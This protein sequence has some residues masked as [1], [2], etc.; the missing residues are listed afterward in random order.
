MRKIALLALPAVSMAFG[1]A[2]PFGTTHGLARA[3]SARS[4]AVPALRMAV[5]EVN[6]AEDLDGQIAGAGRLPQELVCRT[7]A[8][9]VG[10]VREGAWQIDPD[11]SASSPPAPVALAVG[12]WL[13]DAV[14]AASSEPCS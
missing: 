5:L 8:C 10:N 4:A 7:G 1:P 6:S 9:T 13:L 14:P 12:I 11:L 2:M 3:T